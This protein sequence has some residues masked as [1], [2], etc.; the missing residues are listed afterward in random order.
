MT[1]VRTFALAG[2]L[3]LTV[4]AAAQ[5]AGRKSWNEGWTFS[6]D[7]TI[8]A[9]MLP[10][11][12]ET[13]RPEQATYTKILTLSPRDLQKD[14]RL[15]LDGAL[16]G[17]LVY[18]NGSEVGVCADSARAVELN[19]YLS[20]G[21]NVVEIIQ[22][23]R[24]GGL[25]RDVWLTATEK[26]SVAYGGLS[27]TAQPLSGG[28]ARVSLRIRLKSDSLQEAGIHSSVLYC[29]A[30]GEQMAAE[31][32][33]RERVY[34][35]KEV[36]QLF[37]L[38]D[39]QLWTPQTPNRYV[40]RVTIEGA[41]GSRDIYSKFFCVRGADVPLK[42]VSLRREDRVFGDLWQE[43]ALARCLVKLHGMG[44][45][46]LCVGKESYAPGLPELCD[47][48]G[49]VLSR[50]LSA[51]ESIADLLDADGFPLAQEKGRAPGSAFKLSPSVDYQGSELC[52][53]VV[54]VLD[55]AGTRVPG[56]AAR[57]SFTLQGPAHLVTPGTDVPASTGRVLAIVR[58]TGEGP[59]TLSVTA[60]GFRKAVISL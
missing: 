40:V 8:C 6:R 37:D 56:T 23:G 52:Y 55:R 47:R 57:L 53:V 31:C 10:H 46:A 34:D 24:R 51:K 3:A 59:V 22:E 43:D 13:E 17:A 38:E 48:L 49:F 29:G 27:I 19:P 30:G 58:R 35:G 11:I 14:L 54:D 15:E 4:V 33:S 18:V 5:P 21:N 16:G 25:H 41:D 50:D 39:V 28:R 1:I 20:A 7:R 32:R 9:V 44:Y 60:R 36:E 42:G 2:A 26:T 45:N 12:W